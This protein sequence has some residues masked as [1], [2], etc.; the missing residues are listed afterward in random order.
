MKII[1]LSGS[2]KAPNI[3]VGEI[4]TNAKIEWDGSMK[5]EKGGGGGGL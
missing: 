5:K 4:P 3:K 2:P 1:F